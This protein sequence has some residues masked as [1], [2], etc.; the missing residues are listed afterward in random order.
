ML[1]RPDATNDDKVL[2]ILDITLTSLSMLAAIAVLIIF[3]LKKSMRKYLRKP[4]TRNIFHMSCYLLI[5]NVTFFFGQAVTYP[6]NDQPKDC[7]LVAILLHWV[8]D[9]FFIKVFYVAVIMLSG[10]RQK[11]S[12]YVYWGRRN[13]K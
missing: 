6:E 13:Y 9:A 7:L 12:R 8:I 3:K 5:M 4:I 1:F 2:T 10:S 11:F